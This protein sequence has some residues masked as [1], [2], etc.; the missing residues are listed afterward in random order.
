MFG[1]AVP[2]LDGTTRDSQVWWRFFEFILGQEDEQ[3]TVL[4]WRVSSTLINKRISVLYLI[5]ILFCHLHIVT[6]FDIGI[7]KL[8][9]K[10]GEENAKKTNLPV[11]HKFPVTARV[12]V[13]MATASSATQTVRG[14]GRHVSQHMGM[15]RNKHRSFQHR[16]FDHRVHAVRCLHYLDL[17]KPKCP[18]YRGRG[19][20]HNNLVNLHT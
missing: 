14:R 9:R 13:A 18:A 8:I 3:S 1:F 16:L 15:D 7:P 17:N 19:G 20:W 5:S 2:L 10:W 4:F 6:S 11:S 12:A